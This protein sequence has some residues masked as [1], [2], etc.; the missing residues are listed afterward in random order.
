[1][2]ETYERGLERV[3]E[4]HRTL[5]SLGI[6]CHSGSSTGS[7]N[8]KALSEEENIKGVRRGAE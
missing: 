4:S 6:H 1:M 7:S 8:T 2:E 5:Y 3:L